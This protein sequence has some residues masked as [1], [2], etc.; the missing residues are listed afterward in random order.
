MLFNKGLK[1]SQHDYFIKSVHFIMLG[2]YSLYFIIGISINC[3]SAILVINGSFAMIIPRSSPS[4]SSSCNSIPDTE[5]IYAFKVWIVVNIKQ[6]H[7]NYT[8]PK[9]NVF[10]KRINIYYLSIILKVHLEFIN[11]RNTN[12]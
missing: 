1:H 6:F 11:I 5:I 9:I 4:Y 3:R 7:S 8:I 10:W 12:A 2:I